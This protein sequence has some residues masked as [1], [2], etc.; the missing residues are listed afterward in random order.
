MAPDAIA[1]V[2][3]LGR[4]LCALAE[5]IGDREQ[6]SNG[7]RHLLGALLTAGEVDEAR[8]ELDEAGRLA[9]E[10]GQPAHVWGI[11]TAVSMLALCEGR[12]GEA[13]AVADQVRELG[14]RAQPEMAIPVHRMQRYTLCEFRGRLAELEA[15]IVELAARHPARP[16][17]RCVVAHLHARLG[18]LADARR[19]FDELARDRF[20]G[21]PF[22]QEWL[23]GMS[24]LAE[25][26]ALLGDADAGS[27][28]YALLEPWA[29]L[30]VVDQCE[31]MRG[32][33]ARY[34]GILATTAGAAVAAERHFEAA[35]A[36]NARTGARP[37][38]AHTRADYARMLEA[39][40]GDRD[41]ERA[42]VL[43]EAARADYRRLGITAAI[44]RE[45]S[46]A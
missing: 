30:H 41:R 34:L 33:V 5:R 42:R 3:A 26:V 45:S 23:F 31:G 38:L 7:R 8:R 18:Q 21:L 10:L 43:A 4:E 1:E 27:V 15:P 16:V 28:L 37:W 11:E 9:R 22:D 35:L 19:A 44:Y 14:E 36:A 39:R 2:A 24:F 13:E 40:G 6:A 12:L 20:A 32:S 46:I 25:T 17:F 29:H